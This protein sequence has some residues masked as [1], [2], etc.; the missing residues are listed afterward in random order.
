MA[1]NWITFIA[2]VLVVWPIIHGAMRGFANEAGYVVTHLISLAAGVVAIIAG[3]WGSIKLASAFGHASANS[4]PHW[5][6][7]LVQAWQQAPNVAR[8]I[9]FVLV[10]FVV[11]S[12]IHN[13]LRFLPAVTTRVIPKFVAGSHS[14]GAVLGVA[15]GV[16][17]T[18][19][20]GALLYVVMQYFSVPA[21]ANQANHS[22]L[23]QT[24]K[25][26]VYS[27]W[28]DPLL[29]RELPVLA[30]GALEPLTNNINLVAVPSL[31]NGQEQGILIVPKKISDL[32]H[33]ITGKTTNPKQKA[34]LL[35]EWEIH[36]IHYDW[37]KYNDYVRYG[38]WDSQTPLQTLKTGKGVCSDYA[39]LYAELAHASGLKVAIVDGIGGTPSD[40]GAHAWNKVYLP[41]QHKWITVDTT[42]GSSQD[43][44]FDAPNFNQTHITQQTIV[45]AEAKH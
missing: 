24:L 12:I 8:L 35:Y 42:W 22:K 1:F 26:S 4:L 7:N 34:Y 40:H 44:W 27:P 38:K 20:I 21:L 23:Y 5:L 31:T 17:R 18:L 39:L 11:S 43:K 37:K 14:L 30:T 9:A 29:N 16:A 28:L 3:W 41:S 45:I 13:L 25:T 32:A 6:G 36:H 19:V 33:Q 15:V 2:I 10:Y